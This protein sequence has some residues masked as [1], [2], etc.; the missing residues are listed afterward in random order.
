[1]ADESLEGLT[2]NQRQALNLGRLLLEKNP[3]IARKAKR[4]AKEADPTL[5]VPEIEL[6]DQIAAGNKAQADRIAEL[7]QRQI[8]SDVERRRER[9][10]T[11][12]REQG[13]N[14][15]EVEKIVVDEKCSTSTAIKLA[16]AERTTG[17]PS[18]G[19]VSHGNAPHT[20]IDPRPDAEWRKLGGNKSALARRSHDIAAE[21]MDGFKR[22]RRAGAR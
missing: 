19:D 2:P 1:M 4:L 15:E 9:F 11:A 13:L 7:E 16:L 21:M 22:E 3:D 5:R 20:P 8:Q 14:P 10:H 6:E 12:C 17:D 18:A